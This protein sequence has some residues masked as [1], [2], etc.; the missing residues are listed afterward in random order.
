MK[1]GFL[2][3]AALLVFGTQAKAQDAGCGL[4]SMIITENTKLMQL[5]ATTTN[6][7]TFSQAGGITTGTSGCKAQNFVMREKAVH[8]FAEVNKDDLSRE[9]AQGEGEKLTTLASLYGC[10]GNARQDFARAMQ[11]GYDRIIPAADTKVTDMVQNIHREVKAN[12]VLAKGCAV[13][14]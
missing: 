9:M 2:L 6:G 10:E 13:E 3:A 12:A 1:L 4:G 11:S 14:I 7:A 5:L 8:Y